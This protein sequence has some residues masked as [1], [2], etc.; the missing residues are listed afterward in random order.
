M[1]RLQSPLSQVKGDTVAPQR[2][3][4]QGHCC[5][6][7]NECDVDGKKQRFVVHSTKICNAI[8]R[9]MNYDAMKHDFVMHSRPDVFGG[10]QGAS[11]HSNAIYLGTDAG[12][13]VMVSSPPPPF[14]SHTYTPP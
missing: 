3:K 10:I 13:V 14:P 1:S 9:T 2:Q 12:H 7:R 5:H 8:A 4:K 11:F 6:T